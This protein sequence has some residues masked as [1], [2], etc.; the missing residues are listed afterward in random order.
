MCLEHVI[1]WLDWT[2]VEPP[3]MTYQSLGGE[4]GPTLSEP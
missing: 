2:L 4:S 1:V 3:T